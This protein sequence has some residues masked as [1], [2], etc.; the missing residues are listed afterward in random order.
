L[1]GFAKVELQPRETRHVTID[2]DARSFAYYDAAARQW[3]ITPGTFEI[4][5]GRSSEEIL[6]KGSV[7][8]TEAVAKTK[9]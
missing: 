9:M 1:K 7:E 4:L 6:L 5:V 2:L 3:R 8:V